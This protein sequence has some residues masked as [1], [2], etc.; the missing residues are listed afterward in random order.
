EEILVPFAARKLRRPV[1]WVEDRLEHMVA[2]N[3]EREQIHNAAIAVR[4]DG[5]ILAVRDTFSY[6]TGAYIPYGLNVPN[7][8]ALTVPGPYHVANYAVEYRAVYTNRTIVSPYRGAGRP[9][10]VFV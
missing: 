1:K 7:V 10:A 3:H 6:D 4:A 9:H 8:T 2:T 5:T